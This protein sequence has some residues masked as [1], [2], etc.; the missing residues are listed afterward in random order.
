LLTQLRVAGV[1][2][3]ASSPDSREALAPWQLNWR[4]PA[5]LLVGNEGAGLPAELLRSADAI[6]RI[7]QFTDESAGVDS[8]NAAVAGSILLFE[9]ARQ[10]GRD[11][12]ALPRKK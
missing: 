12:D 5:A 8:L 1:S 10:R 2:V 6:V 4:S 11:D 7:P 9:A 3:Y